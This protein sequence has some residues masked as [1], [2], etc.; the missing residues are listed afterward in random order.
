MRRLTALIAITAALCVG[1]AYA[2]RI[3]E[4]SLALSPATQS[5][6][7][8]TINTIFQDRHGFIWLLS[9]EGVNRF[10]GYE[11]VS[12][13]TIRGDETSLSH[14]LATGIVEDENGQIWIATAEGG[15]N[16]FEEHNFTFRSIRSGEVP[17]S[18]QPTSDQVTT[19]SNGIDGRLWV[20]Y[21]NGKGISVFFPETE[22]FTHYPLPY[23]QSDHVVEAILETSLE[24]VYVAV[25][26][27][28]IFRLD[29]E[30]NELVKVPFA[31][32]QNSSNQVGQPT[33]MQEL[34]SKEILITS[35][36]EGAYIFTPVDSSIR[37]HPIHELSAS[38]TINEIYS[39][40]VDTQGNHWFGTRSGVA[41]YD[42]NGNI[43]WINS[44]NSEI[45]DDEVRDIFKSRDG[46]VWIGTYN[47][48]AQGAPTLFQKFTADDG[49]ASSA[50]YAIDSDIEG[51]WWLG[52]QKGL[53]KIA[54]SIGDDGA[55][56]ILDRPTL[57]LQDIIV[58]SVA[59]TDEYVFA[60]SLRSGLF[61]IEIATGAI[62]RYLSSDTE[63]SISNDGVPVVKAVNKKTMLIGTFGGGLN[64]LDIES[65]RF[66]HLRHDPNDPTTISDDRVISALRD[67]ASRIWIGTQNGLNLFNSEKQSF[68]RY[69][70]DSNDESTLTSRVVLSLAQNLDGDLLIGTR[71]GG[72][73]ILPSEEIDKPN[74]AFELPPKNIK[75]PSADIY[76][77]LPDSTGKLWLSHNAGISV[78]NENW[79]DS[80]NFDEKSGLQGPEF[81]H[82]AANQTK[83]GS[84]L[85]GGQ[86][87]F[88]VIAPEKG[89]VDKYTPSLVFTS[90]KKLNEHVFFESPYSTL[91]TVEL[92]HDYQ[93]VSL[94]FSALD[95][96]AP[97]RI[98]Y[99]YRID[100]L[101]N[102][103]ID[104]ATNRLI[105]ISGLGYGNYRIRVR[106]TNSSEVWSENQQTLGL[107]IH[108]PFWMTNYAFLLYALL[109]LLTGYAI[110]RRQQLKT[111]L[112]VSRRVELEKKVRER[113]YDLQVARE[114]AEHSA[115]AKADF[116]AAMSHEIRT[117]MHGMLGMT[118]LLMQS[119]LTPQQSAYARTA[120]E[121]GSS[122]LEIVNSILDYS[123]LEAGKLQLSLSEFELRSLVDDV[124]TLLTTQAAETDTRVYV[125]W[126][127]CTTDFVIGDKGKIRQIL[128]NLI[129]NAIKFTRGGIVTVYCDAVARY[130]AD[131]NHSHVKCRFQ[132]HDSGIGIPEEK[133]ETIFEVFTQ[134][135]AS[136]TREFGGTGLGLSITKEL[137]DLM[138]G[139]IGVESRVGQGSE[140][141]FEIGLET[142]QKPR[143]E[144]ITYPDPVICVT[145]NKALYFSI[146]SK[147]RLNGFQTL[148][149]SYTEAYKETHS[150]RQIFLIDDFD[151]SESE[152]GRLS[153]HRKIIVLG[154]SVSKSFTNAVNYIMPP[155][156]EGEVVNEVRQ[157]SLSSYPHDVLEE[158]GEITGP[159]SH[160]ALLVED[161]EVNQEIAQHMLKSICG[162]IATASN[163]LEAIER[164]K[165][166]QFDIIFMDCQ[167][168]VMDGYQA[169]RNIRKIE[170]ELRQRPTPI[171]ALTAGGDPGEEKRVTEAGMDGLVRKP[172]SA[173]DLDE[174]IR[175]YCMRGEVTGD[176]VASSAATFQDGPELSL[177]A[178]LDFDVIDGLKKLD[179]EGIGSALLQKLQEGF[180]AQFVEK[181]RL[182]RS[183]ISNMNRTDIKSHAHAIKSMS[184]NMGARKLRGIAETIE[185]NS[186]TADQSFLEVEALKLSDEI[187]IFQ[188]LFRDYVK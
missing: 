74:P 171:V 47:G 66:T 49:L 163:G 170:A 150:Q 146:E 97:E 19:I 136:T 79:S 33:S 152:F 43:I 71:S 141:W 52:T 13:T 114:E 164:F 113:T 91:S 144:P 8:Q 109:L 16:L 7:Q 35:I 65:N 121:S 42:Q 122:L 31:Q 130:E 104:L 18:K 82:G 69:T 93:F 176:T 154:N 17:N 143:D 183:E 134:A 157:A 63:S 62:E 159:S 87:G 77:I 145:E 21:G 106:S 24:Q 27:A 153:E 180:S 59:V 135:D 115:Q 178:S 88:N 129:G 151:L 184:A 120:R 39:V 187:P 10:D 29:T 126:R 131:Q 32:G 73:N 111:Q 166:E 44:F 188:E 70:Y 160:S 110:V 124:A 161:M 149:C 60:G 142:V 165:L 132:V 61:R 125:V 34:D 156:T 92:S 50:I 72:L 137:V 98:A 186:R 100:G 96:R 67:D 76:G 51:N 168:P 101:H 167:M 68:T 28:G 46:T 94:S 57:L 107:T 2:F 116:L 123:K 86:Q 118:D 138:D 162:N 1:Q 25:D 14:Q 48:L 185:Q 36:S 78:I 179:Q 173:Q 3:D 9:Q 158:I 22:T 85:F 26:K 58:M 147:L 53:A 45:P 81:N 172:F 6:S 95:F 133:L 83:D 177:E 169:A 155:Y 41:V 54:P 15:L 56:Q 99:Q 5:L 128:I 12:F 90:F 80:Y 127:A 117:P 181:L 103:W 148:Q 139:T 175:I 11:V 112:E 75:L 20:G 140:F 37:P 40:F 55:W 102:E 30:R 84:L 89:Y 4:Y 23:Q 105:T 182:L 119:A 64:L 108:P 174:A 38:G